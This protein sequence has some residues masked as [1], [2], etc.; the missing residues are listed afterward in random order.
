MPFKNIQKDKTGRIIGERKLGE[1]KEKS[2]P[3]LPDL[4]RTLRA[5][6]HRQA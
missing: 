2:H 5:Q 4:R 1:G 3:G 6:T